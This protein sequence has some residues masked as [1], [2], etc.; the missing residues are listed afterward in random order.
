MRSGILITLVDHACAEHN[1]IIMRPKRPLH[2]TSRPYDQKTKIPFLDF[3]ELYSL[4]VFF[5][6]LFWFLV[7]LLRCLPVDEPQLLFFLSAHELLANLPREATYLSCDV[8]LHLDT[9]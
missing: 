6:S 9:G 1:P 3:T 8:L 4:A 7:V 5:F 2:I